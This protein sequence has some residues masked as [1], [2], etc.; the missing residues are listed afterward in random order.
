MHQ[1]Q[2]YILSG[3]NATENTLTT[4]LKVFTMCQATR[5]DLKSFHMENRIQKLWNNGTNK[6]AKK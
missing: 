6:E 3:L 4:N 1:A 5:Q 2:N